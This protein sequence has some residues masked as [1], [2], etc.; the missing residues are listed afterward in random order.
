MRII[1][2]CGCCAALGAAVYQAP[3]P[4]PTD[5]E[6]VILEYINRFR[7][8]PAAEADRILAAKGRLWTPKGLDWQM[9]EQEVKALKPAPP[10]VF[11]LAAL[12]SARRHSFYMLHNGLGHV[13]EAGKEGFTGKSFSDRMKAAGF[14]GGPGGENC[15]R[16][17]GG[18]EHSCMGFIIDFGDGG[19]GGMQPG[20]GHRT[21]LA[22]PG[23]NVMG[24]GALP[25][26]GNR[27]AVTHNLG[28][29]KGRFAGGVVYVDRDRDG[30]YDAGEGRGGVVVTTADG[31]ARAITW[32]SGAY[33]LP[34][35]GDAAGELVAEAGGLR[36]ALPFAA[37]KDNLTF[38]WAIPPEEDLKRADMLIARVEALPDDGGQ[39]RSRFTSLVELH[40]TAT[41]LCLD[42]PRRERV[43]ALTAVVGPQVV[44][45]TAAL[46]AAVDG[47]DA[48]AAAALVRAGRQTYRGTAREPLYLDAAVFLEAKRA[49]G[50]VVAR[51]EAFTG[52][53]KAKLVELVAQTREKV[54]TGEFLTRVDALIVRARDLA[55]AGPPAP[56][57]RDH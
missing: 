31:K 7:A 28:R 29:V 8:D 19:P 27:L 16:D 50:N 46:L 55:A 33:A 17:S 51:P 39:T 9:F 2:L 47:D 23:F 38:S 14:A 42:P 41:V 35:P 20:R 36:Y 48:A 43:A 12:A 54:V 57:G 44:A 30:A 11:D 53:Q 22:N 25:H 32:T 26:G 45:D 21:N 34:L 4:E 15:Y 52:A 24:P 1:L 13:E 49:V 10:L 18:A 37:G 6:T 3:S 5:E 56:R 40:L